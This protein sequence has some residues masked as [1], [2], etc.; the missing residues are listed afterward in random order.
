MLRWVFRVV[1]F[2]LLVVFTILQ[3][4]THAFSGTIWKIIKW[5]PVFFVVVYSAAYLSVFHGDSLG[6][7]IS[8]RVN[9]SRRGTFTLGK[10]EYSYFGGM[11]SVLF[12]RPVPVVA[13]DYTLLDPEGN[14][15]LKIPRVEADIH[16]RELLLALARFPLSGLRAF[17]ITLH[18][19]HVH[20]PEAM[21]VIAPTRSGWVPS[22]PGQPPPKQEINILAAMSPQVITPPAGGDFRVILEDLQIDKLYF[23]I[24][25]PATDGTRSWSA[26][27]EDGPARASLIYSSRADLETSDGPY[28][29]FHVQPLV[30]P[31]GEL[32]LGDSVLPLEDV[33]VSEFGHH[34]PRRQEILFHAKAKSLGASIDAAGALTDVFSKQPG[35][36]MILDFEH[37]GRP[38]QLLPPPV[39]GWVSG[40]P[41]GSIRIAGP[42]S[43]PSLAGE[44]EG[45]EVH[46]FGL[47]VKEAKASMKLFDGKLTLEPVSGAAAGGTVKGAV[48]VSLPAHKHAGWWRLRLTTKDVD[49]S[50]VAPLPPELKKQLAGR[51]DGNVRLGGSFA[52]YSDTIN[53]TALEAT[54]RR[55]RPG[56]LPQTLKVMGALDY[57]PKEIAMKKLSVTG[58]GGEVV[59]DGTVDPRSGAVHAELSVHNLHGGR[60]LDRLG[61]PDSVDVGDGRAEL[62]VRGTLDHPQV[63]GRISVENLGIVGRVL[64]KLATEV[65]LKDGILSLVGF[66]TG[67]LGTQIIG[68]A[69]LDLFEGGRLSRMRAQ[70]T[71]KASL[72][73]RAAKLSAILGRSAFEGDADL[74]LEIAGPLRDPVGTLTAELPR[75]SW[76]GDPYLHGKLS[77]ELGGGGAIVRALS[78][79]R[80]NGGALTGSGRVG[81][82]GALDLRLQLAKFPLTAIPSVA[83]LPIPIGGNV[84]G[85]VTVGGDTLHV[86]LSG[87]VSLLG[88]SV[89]DTLFGDGQLRFEPGA[90]AIAIRGKL[91]GKVDVDAYLT[92]FPKFSITGTLAFQDLELER[93]FPELRKFAEISG[94]ASGQARIVLDGEN[95]LTYAGLK[96][97][98]LT[99]TLSGTDETGHPQKE[100]VRNEE[101]VLLSTDG[102][103]LRLDR[104]HLISTVGDFVMKGQVGGAATDLALRGKVD[105]VLLEYFFRSAFDHTHGRASI[106]LTVKGDL[107]KPVL[108]G[109][110]DLQNGVLQPRGF[111]H[112][113]NVPFAR[114][115]FSENEIRLAS[116]SLSMDNQTV[117]GEGSVKM[118]HWVPRDIR[119]SI[120]GDLSARLIQWMF[121][122]QVSESTG[123]IAIN[124]KISGTWSSPR[125]DGRADLKGLSGKLRRMGYEL[126]VTDG[127]LALEGT[128]I[129]AGCPK[130]NAPAG[131]RRLVGTLD[132]HPASLNGR[133]DLGPDLGL[134][135]LD[136]TLDGSEWSYSQSN[137]WSVS[138]SPRLTLSGSVP[139]LS[140]SGTIDLVD[141]RYS[142]PFDMIGLFLVARRT[143][144]SP[145]A[146]F[147]VG[148]PVLENIELDLDVRSAGQLL[149]RNNIADLTMS[150]KLHVGGTLESPQLGGGITLDEGGTFKP[151]GSVISFI[152]RR[153]DV[154]F[155]P[156]KSIPKETPS[157]N[158]NASGS[159]TDST[160]DR[161]TTIDLALTGTLGAPQ[162]L[163]SSPS[164]G[165]DQNACL[166]FVLTG[167]TPAQLRQRYGGGSGSQDPGR[168]LGGGTGASTSASDNLTKSVS[169]MLVGNTLSS[170]LKNLLRLDSAG[171]Q[172]GTN[173][174]DVNLCYGAG[175]VL[176]VCGLGQVGFAGA[177]RV[178]ARVEGRYM[179][180]FT[181]QLR[182]EYVTGRNVETNQDSTT[183]LRLEPIRIQIPFWF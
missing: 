43:R 22:K 79:D 145:E 148:Q 64:L 89:R 53:I 82:D 95:G 116:L 30:S 110:I 140:A 69:D 92:L 158:L 23:G 105:F 16:I 157:L 83:A 164:D 31:R 165:W 137:K 32:V 38:A 66:K 71:L 143:N 14:V 8:A 183:R 139:H 171:F 132:D 151:P 149:V 117:T 134:K 7:F 40:D 159:T 180:G 147:W 57:A 37:A 122:E 39:A 100:V 73:A 4:I 138:F 111:E 108:V 77:L 142:E 88:F 103:V 113:L 24:G 99:L 65:H 175:R 126:A 127:T 11:A 135:S 96:V 125:F 153:G 20:I 62:S 55:D 87:L 182:F 123:K 70:P 169:G 128:R 176:R 29:F 141:G 118:D 129:W 109:W 160:T 17:S 150:A 91:F 161:T 119:G 80:Q 48:E 5:F 44:F 112:K 130:T 46:A 54:L 42:F 101:D 41:R 27:L 166:T 81:W 86:A 28:F 181:G 152:T 9:S 2:P 168:G 124:T 178:E 93:I 68:S 56:K 163:L 26:R 1:T 19:S 162:L 121:T 15:V 136:L 58:E 67:G 51:L 72:S 50:K 144:E 35:V 76:S 106:D 154:L 13:H 33:R 115:A 94:R 85:D 34:E 60:W 84:S 172:V 49:P 61:L 133:I 131:C 173:S 63:D 6:A 104:V 90:D 10:C 21:A 52:K 107:S 59:A 155:R 36:K 78:V 120:R 74:Q 18:F 75:F 47:E 174:L 167:A 25:F 102:K 97:E 146:P 3:W 12:N 98:K 45:A 114:V 179:D 177:S 170:P 156:G